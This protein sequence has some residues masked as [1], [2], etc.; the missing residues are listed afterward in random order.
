MSKDPMTVGNG[1]VVNSEVLMQM[2]VMEPGVLEER[3][4]EHIVGS[5]NRH[6]IKLYLLILWYVIPVTI[7]CV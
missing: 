6:T 4:T 7:R 5:I 3:L 2:I 1:K